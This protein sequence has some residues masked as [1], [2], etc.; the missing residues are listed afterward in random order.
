MSKVW[1]IKYVIPLRWFA[2]HSERTSE[3]SDISYS[4]CERDFFFQVFS[5][6]VLIEVLL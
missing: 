3:N 1:L 4:D 2:I 5:Q 6:K